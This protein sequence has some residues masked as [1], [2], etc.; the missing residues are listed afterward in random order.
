MT[1][2]SFRAIATAVVCAWAASVHAQSIDLP[3]GKQIV[4][5]VPGGPERLNSLP[6]SMAVSPDR[7]F[8][9]TVNAGYGTYESKYMQSLA[10]MDTET[11]KITDFPDD[12]T[13]GKLPQTLYSGLAFSR[14]GG[15]IYV[16]MASLSDPLG[17]GLE[18]TGSGVAVYR[19]SNGVV[20]PERM[21][22][23]PLQQLAAGRKTLLIGGKE[24]DQGAPYPA[25][26]AVVNAGGAE[27][28]LV[29]D[30][31]SDDVL[32]MD[33]A[34]GA[35]EKRFDLAES[36]AVPS[37]YPVTLAVSKD[38]AR[39]FVAL[40]N[41]SEIA[42]LDLANGKVG[43][44]LPLLKPQDTIVAGTHPCAMEVSP[45]GRTLYVALAN[46][47][48]VAAVD[49]GAGQFAVKG[50][51]D[52][53]LPHQTYFGA[54]PAS[55]AISADGSRLYAGNAMTDSVAVLD[56]TKLTA[57]TAK[58]GMVEPLGFIPTEWMPMSM[59]MIGD[60]L[61]LAA[62]KGKGTGPNNMP[63]R[64]DSIQTEQAKSSTDTTATA[65]HTH[66]HSASALD[67]TYIA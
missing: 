7:R 49:I 31:L 44:K 9:V 25:A 65:R 66:Q 27:K 11:G 2:V 51:F 14:D 32:L 59:A 47:D 12:R 6:I 15:H 28:L 20:T 3:T 54:E 64:M 35:I 16:S 24:G 29:A 13:R 1:S 57:K 40:W 53:R 46:R 26:I 36:D 45:D 4:R 33:A 21:M 48:A 55:L 17:K 42:E 61:Y 34:T 62:A 52:T 38:G 43:R 23:I 22:K 10:V 8:V 39:A 37:A 67:R 56:T 30:N 60:K 19:F 41:A 50:Y 5:P 58:Q 18:S 63:Q